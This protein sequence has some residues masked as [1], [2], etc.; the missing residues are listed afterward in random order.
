MNTRLLTA[1]L[2]IVFLLLTACGGS[3]SS[4]SSGSTPISLSAVAAVFP[5]NG[6][7]WNDYVTGTVATATDTACV[8]ATD[9]VCVHGGERR[10]VQVTGRS[11]CTGLTA[12]DSLGAF[13]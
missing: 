12:T 7:N 1:L 11:D 5:T 10:V 6:A 3:S 8:A 2:P 9:T 4:S 13:T